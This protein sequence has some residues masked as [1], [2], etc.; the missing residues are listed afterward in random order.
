MLPEPTEAAMSRKRKVTTAIRSAATVGRWKEDG[1]SVLPPTTD[2]AE[3]RRRK[4][5]AYD[6]MVR[7]TCDA[8]RDPSPLPVATDAAPPPHR[9]AAPVGRD[10]QTS[11]KEAVRK[12]LEAYGRI[13]CAAEP[14]ADAWR[15]TRRD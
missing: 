11:P 6:A 3:G 14:D 12:R 5:Q 9:D 1:A 10:L 2:A 4:Q 8:W 15:R 7:E 13:A